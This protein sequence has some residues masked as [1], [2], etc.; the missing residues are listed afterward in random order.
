MLKRNLICFILL[1]VVLSVSAQVKRPDYE[2]YIEKWSQT[3]LEQQ[4]AHKI[5]AYITIAQGLLESGAGKSELATQANNHFGI[6]CHEWLGSTY[7]VDDDKP[8]ECFRKYEKASESFTDHSLFLQRSRYSSLFALEMSDYKGWA[9]GLSKCGYATDPQYANKLIKI[10]EDYGLLSLMDKSLVIEN[11]FGE[12]ITV[13]ALPKL[14]ANKHLPGIQI[15]HQF[16]RRKRGTRYV[17][18]KEGDTFARLAFLANMNEKTLRRYNNAKNGRAP[19]AGE[20][21]YFF[22]NKEQANKK[23]EDSKQTDSQTENS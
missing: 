11:Q 15:F 3:A 1:C 18:A 17:V 10:I 23:I 6:K 12:E 14:I 19:Q 16:N 7:H 13:V 5:P 20:K 8:N 22:Y 2:N 4:K 9:T 21:I